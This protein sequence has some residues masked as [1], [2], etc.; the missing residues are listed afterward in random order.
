MLPC[1]NTLTTP[2]LS[3]T[4]TNVRISVFVVAIGGE[5]PDHLT[6]LVTVFPSTVQ[7]SPY[8]AAVLASMNSVT[9]IDCPFP[10]ALPFE[11]SVLNAQVLIA[12]VGVVP[13]IV[14]AAAVT[15]FN[16]FPVT[17]KFA[18]KLLNVCSIT[19]PPNT[20][21]PST[22]R[23]GFVSPAGTDKTPTDVSL[24]FT[25]VSPRLVESNTFW[26]PITN[27]L[28]DLSS[29]FSDKTQYLSVLEWS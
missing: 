5:P 13:R 25:T 14:L 18:E 1:P 4:I 11:S 23:A 19:L 7:S 29:K 28:P 12:D 21:E 16:V 15:T 26:F 20:I 3:F 8:V 22:S 10:R 9:V 2:E 17:V 27:F 6:P 24:E